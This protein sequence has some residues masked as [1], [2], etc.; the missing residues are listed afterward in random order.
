MTSKIVLRAAPTL[1]EPK[2]V[3]SAISANTSNAQGAGFHSN[4]E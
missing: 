4:A 3:Q 1:F 2:Q